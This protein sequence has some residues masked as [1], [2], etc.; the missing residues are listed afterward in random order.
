MQ[1]EGAIG[2]TAHYAIGIAFASVLVLVCGESWVRQPSLVPALALG[3]LTVAA[4]FLLMQPA[5]GFGIAS[6]RAPRPGA[7]RLRSLATHAAFGVSLF[8]AAWI[9]AQLMP[10]SR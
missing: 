10:L 9:L 5:M 8:A 4:P 1:G 2:W 3:V 7:A 6:S